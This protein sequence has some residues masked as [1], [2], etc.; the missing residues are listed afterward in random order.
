MYGA[1]FFLKKYDNRTLYVRGG[2]DKMTGEQYSTEGMDDVL[3][4]CK[5]NVGQS[6]IWNEPILLQ[7]LDNLAKMGWIKPAQYYERIKTMNIIPNIQG[8]I[9]DA[10]LEQ[11]AQAK[12]QEQLEQMQMMVGKPPKP[13]PDPMNNP[14]LQGQFGQTAQNDMRT[15]QP[16]QPF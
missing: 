9:A 11:M 6:T 7:N 1:N 16:N 5:V 15:S 13:P 4:S 10:K 12:K 3:L 2:N 14:E 8:L